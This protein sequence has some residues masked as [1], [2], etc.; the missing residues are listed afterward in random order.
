MG[1][2][3][4]RQVVSEGL[5]LSSAHGTHSSERPWSV[6]TQFDFANGSYLSLSTGTVTVAL[7][8]CLLCTFQKQIIPSHN[9]KSQSAKRF[10]KVTVP[11]DAAF[12][13]KTIRKGYPDGT[14]H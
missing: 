12:D 6:A 3:Y 4:Q 9:T 8:A 10:T 2:D 7:N 13:A 5:C 1:L 11:P 14:I